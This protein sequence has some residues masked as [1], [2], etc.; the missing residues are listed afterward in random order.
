M[1]GELKCFKVRN[2]SVVDDV[3]VVDDRNDVE[4]GGDAN[5]LYMKSFQGILP[6]FEVD[7]LSTV[8]VHSTSMSKDWYLLF[9]S[10]HCYKR[11][12]RDQYPSS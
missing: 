9:V 7:V 1:G 8:D 5:D 11:T 12:K 4:E 6:S 3:D 2:V 10:N